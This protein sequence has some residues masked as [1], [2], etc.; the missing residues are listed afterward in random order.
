[1]SQNWCGQDHLTA[2]KADLGTILEFPIPP[3]NFSFAQ[4]MHDPQCKIIQLH[5]ITHLNHK[6]GKKMRNT[7]LL[8]LYAQPQVF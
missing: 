3:H 6:C 2:L 8:C 5:C 1:M 4:R 7:T